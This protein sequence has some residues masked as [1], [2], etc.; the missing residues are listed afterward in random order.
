M[1]VRE[2]GIFWETMYSGKYLMTVYPGGGISELVSVTFVAGI[3]ICYS[4]NS[5][6]QIEPKNYSQLLPAGL[7]SKIFFKRRCENTVI[8][9]II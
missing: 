9:I 4:G 5:V 8:V 7:C 6:G 2:K 1:Q 3:L